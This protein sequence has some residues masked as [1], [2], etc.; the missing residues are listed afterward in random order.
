MAKLRASAAPPTGPT[1]NIIGAGTV[2]EGSLRSKADIH[3]GGE[4]KG[5][6]HVEGRTV[7]SGEGK[8]DGTLESG[9]AD[10]SGTVIGDVAVTGRLVLKNTARVEGNISTS[11]LVV[12]DGAVFTGR[13]DMTGL[14]KGGGAKS[15]AK[16]PT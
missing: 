12:E 13:C 4:I 16:L 6:V 7:L 15:S 14:T 8:I 10:L 11:K 2:I 3:I 5:D 9:S 1:N